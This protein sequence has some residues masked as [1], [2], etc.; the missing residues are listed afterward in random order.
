MT[1]GTAEH[2]TSSLAKA[3]DKGQK[4]VILV[5]YIYMRGKVTKVWSYIT[6]DQKTMR[7]F[8]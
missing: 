7:R 5:I 8:I 3:D 6:R 4:L 2:E 1:I